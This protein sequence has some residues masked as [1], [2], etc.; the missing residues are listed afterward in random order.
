MHVSTTGCELG[1]RA[2]P[3]VMFT[4]LVR[5]I[6]EAPDPAYITAMII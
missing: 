2:A 6:K 4:E 1:Q 5:L 3:D